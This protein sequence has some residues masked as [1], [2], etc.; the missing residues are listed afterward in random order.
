[1]Q[2][3]YKCDECQRNHETAEAAEKCERSDRER[4]RINT[5]FRQRKEEE[6]KGELRKW[7]SES[8]AFR[9]LVQHDYTDEARI[10]AKQ[11]IDEYREQVAANWEFCALYQMD[12]LVDMMVQTVR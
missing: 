7:A 11:A 10:L 8:E 12:E 2:V 9:W 6:Q 1:M 3:I 5:L 4:H